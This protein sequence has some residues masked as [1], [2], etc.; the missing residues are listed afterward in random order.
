MYASKRYLQTHHWGAK[1]LPHSGKA[2]RHLKNRLN[3]SMPATV[4]MYFRN[5]IHFF[6]MR[7]YAHL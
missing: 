6:L 3:L 4:V 7:L 1:V 2:R 5:S